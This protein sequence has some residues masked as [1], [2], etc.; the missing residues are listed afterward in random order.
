[1]GGLRFGGWGEFVHVW[2]GSG[3]LPLVI[4]GSRVK[5]RQVLLEFTFVR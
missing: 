3:R 4:I 5:E 1:M 2:E